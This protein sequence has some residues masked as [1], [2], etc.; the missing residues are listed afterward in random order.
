[1]EIWG[2]KIDELAKR[3]R[4]RK[5]RIA[6]SLNLL[7]LPGELQEAVGA[8]DLPVQLAHEVAR[9]AKTED[10][11]RAWELLNAESGLTFHQARAIVH[12]VKREAAGGKQK[13]RQ[14]KSGVQP[15]ANV[16][17]R[18]GTRLLLNSNTKLDDREIVA[19]AAEGMNSL[20]QDWVS[21]RL[22]NYEVDFG[23]AELSD[24]L[25][26]LQSTDFLQAHAG[27]ELDTLCLAALALFEPCL[28]SALNG[29]DPAARREA[30]EF[31]QTL[32]PRT[33]R[34]IAPL[35]KPS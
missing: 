20:A 28:Q 17:I 31:M 8:K 32:K 30:M 18:K 33:R 24:L 12:R 5:G 21:G 1:M 9:L 15:V 10:M 34:V 26:A 27:A 7:R 13:R 4:I 35:G 3:L 2:I 6:R 11:S 14:R 16:S 25:L 29:H 19:C 23:T 22:P